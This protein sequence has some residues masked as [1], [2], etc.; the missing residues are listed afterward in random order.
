MCMV[1]K[2]FFNALR[3]EEHSVVNSTICNDLLSFCHLK[4]I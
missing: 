3:E 4:L 1:A 2:D